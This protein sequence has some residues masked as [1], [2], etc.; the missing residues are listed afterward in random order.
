[1][2]NEAVKKQ[3]LEAYNFR[4][5]CKLFDSAK[6]IDEADMAYILE[7]G[8]LSP[9]SFGMQGVRMIV[10]TDDALKAKLKPAC[11]NQ[12]QIDSCSHL[13]VFTTRTKDLVPGSDWVKSRFADRGMPADAQEAYYTRYAGFHKDMKERVEGFFKRSMVGFFYNMFHHGRNAKAIYNWGAKQCYILLGNMMTA[14]A[15]IGIDSCPIEGFEKNKVE[16]ILGLD[17][18]NEEVVLL[19]PFGYR[20]NDQPEKYRLPI[21][22]IS[23]RR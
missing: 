21:E 7:T 3:V 4:H 20:Q 9:T 13:V 15:M 22:E 10:I 5:A 1:M 19:C 14:A 11:W 6:K 17:T 8:R 16:E 12:N 2:N 23:E 18:E